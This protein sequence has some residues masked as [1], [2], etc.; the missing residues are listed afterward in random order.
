M[1]T[2][3]SKDNIIYNR[4]DNLNYVAFARNQDVLD[5]IINNYQKYNLIINPTLS[6]PLE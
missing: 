4:V 5:F 6:H 3:L 1:K 2:E